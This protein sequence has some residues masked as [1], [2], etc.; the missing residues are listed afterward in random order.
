MNITSCLRRQ[1]YLITTY[2][3]QYTYVCLELYLQTPN[4]TI[5]FEN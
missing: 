1:N 5:N 3:Y 4:G 2:K